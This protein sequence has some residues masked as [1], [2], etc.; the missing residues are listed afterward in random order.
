MI[1]SQSM[2]NKSSEISRRSAMAAAAAPFFVKHLISAP[3]SGFVRLASF[4][5]DGMAFVT[6]NQLAKHPQVK[7]TAVAEID[8]GKLGQLKKS[9]PDVKVYQD[10]RQM[11]AKERKNLDA[12]CVGTPDHM[13]ASQ[14]MGAMRAGLHVYT[15]KPLTHDL[16]EARRLREYAHKK[17]LVS[18]MGIQVHSSAFYR[19]A[20][21]VIQSGAIGDVH[22]VHAWSNKKWGD[23]DPRPART[24]PAPPTLDWDGWQ[25]VVTPRPYINDGYYHPVNWRKRLDFG[26]GTFGDMGCHIF[27]PVFSAMAL[28]APVTVRSEGP[29]PANGNWAIN[30]VVKYVFPA[31]RYSGGEK[32]NVTWY[33]GDARPPE[34]ILKRVEARVP[35]QG[36]I[37]IGSKGV[38]LLPHTGMP[39]L[40]PAANFTDFTI[41][42]VESSSHYFQFVDAVLGKGQTLAPFDYAGPLT[43][44]VLLG[45]V[46]TRFPQTTLEWDAA[47]MKFRNSR[48]ATA[49]VR[50]KYRAGWEMKGLS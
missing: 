37:F 34:D 4:G 5:A 16:F 39:V 12:A 24:D 40:S 35:E 36:S 43:E 41:P 13:H 6:L 10:W 48:E 21:Q 47:K 15:Q 31:S 25:G 46:A 50:R 29:A 1:D 32:I 30:S 17:K 11:L 33:D 7:L 18:Q 2:S 22:E 27:D 9:F 45:G 19:T 42:K 26:T 8:S 23:L 44:S 38:M 14:T 49:L 28:T 3:P 20:V